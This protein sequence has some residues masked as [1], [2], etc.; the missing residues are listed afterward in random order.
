MYATIDFRCNVIY[1]KR[2]ETG[3]ICPNV[4]RSDCLIL[5]FVTQASQLSISIVEYFFIFLSFFDLFEIFLPVYCDII[6]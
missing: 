2:G 3:Y 1:T 5:N 4:Q 6:N